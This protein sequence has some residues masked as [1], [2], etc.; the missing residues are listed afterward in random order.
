M[1][2]SSARTSSSGRPSAFFDSLA[3]YALSRLRFFGRR[4]LFVSILAVMS[5]PGVVLLIPKYLVL[6]Y[7][8]IYNSYSALILPLM[9][10]A[11]GIF[12]S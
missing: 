9:I 12:I 10:D 3:G 2:G 4:F 11:A 6:N 1:L 8:G 7:L 5:V